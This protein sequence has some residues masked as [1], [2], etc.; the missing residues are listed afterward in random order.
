M[1]TANQFANLLQ[2]DNDQVYLGA[3]NLLRRRSSTFPLW[4]AVG[5]FEGAQTG[6]NLLQVINNIGALPLAKKIRYATALAGLYNS[7]P[8]PIYVTP[9]LTLDMADQGDGIGVPRSP[10]IPSHQTDAILALEQISNAAQ[11]GALIAAICNRI[12]TS[13][14]R[15]GIQPWDGL[16]TNA[17]RIAIV[18]GGD[19]AKTDLAL[20]L[21]FDNANAG[22]AIQN[23]LDAMGHAG[24]AGH[25]WLENQIDACPIYDI[26]GVPGLAGSATVHGAGW[27]TAAMINAWSTGAQ[28]FPA[29]LAHPQDQD[30]KIVIGALLHAG[31]AT[32]PGA[33]TIVHWN[34]SDVTLVDT[35][36]VQH[37]RPPYIALA[38][39]LIHAF[40]NISGDQAGHEIDT[41]SRVLYEFQCVGLGPWDGAVLTENDV[42]I[43]AGLAPRLAY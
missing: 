10:A 24:G 37:D 27:V 3:P 5:A 25:I 11:G 32:R 4:Q 13:G 33:H 8:N 2:Q 6:A 19:D 36:G 9:G 42:R 21:E 1:L 30:A 14:N 16:Q 23:A 43:S 7:F 29:P 39:E 22:E 35:L 17:C 31:S 12:G 20:A 18:N 41:Y 34:G 40:H 28:V 38:H 26:Q 15:V